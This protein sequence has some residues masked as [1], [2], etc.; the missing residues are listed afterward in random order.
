MA[1]VLG[2]GGSGAPVSLPVFFLLLGLLCAVFVVM[3]FAAG[4]V[5]R[6]LRDRRA[7]DEPRS[8][9]GADD[10]GDRM[11]VFLLLRLTPVVGLVMI[12]VA[13]V[14]RLSSDS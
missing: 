4:P 13:V 3:L 14:A 2:Q 5:S 9:S 8:T 1:V 6:H 11:L 12:A 7:G 10:G